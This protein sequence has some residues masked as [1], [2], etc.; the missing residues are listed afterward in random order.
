MPTKTYSLN[1]ETIKTI[2][3]LASRTIRTQGAIVD[4]A[5]AYLAAN[6]VAADGGIDLPVVVQPARK[7]RKTARRKPLSQIPGVSKGLVN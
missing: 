3:S 5:V 7:S 4:M 1:P 6:S 2:S